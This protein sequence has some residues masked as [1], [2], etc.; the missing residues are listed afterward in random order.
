MSTR[1]NYPTRRSVPK[2]PA[3]SSAN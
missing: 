2:L 1:I 3:R